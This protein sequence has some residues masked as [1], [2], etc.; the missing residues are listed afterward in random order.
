ME[1]EAGGAVK[2]LP[3]EKSSLP[4]GLKIEGAF[5][6]QITR[7]FIICCNYANFAAKS[8]QCRCNRKGR[9]TEDLVFTG[10]MVAGSFWGICNFGMQKIKTNELNCLRW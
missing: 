10:I 7:V 6:L 2:N 1:G 8:M 9:D 4:L 3:N 5:V